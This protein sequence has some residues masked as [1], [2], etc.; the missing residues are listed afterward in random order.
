[1]RYEPILYRP[2]WRPVVNV[3]DVVDL[4]DSAVQRLLLVEHIEMKPFAVIDWGSVLS[5]VTIAAKAALNA[6]SQDILAVGPDQFAQTRIRLDPRD[7]LSNPTSGNPTLVQAY[8]PGPAAQRWANIYQVYSWDAISQAY[9]ASLN[10][11]PTELFSYYDQTPNYSVINNSGATQATSRIWFMQIVYTGMPLGS[12]P[13]DAA[14]QAAVAKS[15]LGYVA[16]IPVAV[17]QVR[18]RA[19]NPAFN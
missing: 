6:S 13:N 5:T 14:V 7:F 4:L 11:S 10:Q 1:M 9:W 18:N 17:K 12:D 16:Q 2:E 8:Q 19:N 3:G 15:M